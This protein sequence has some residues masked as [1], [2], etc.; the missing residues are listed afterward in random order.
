MIDIHNDP[1]L[2]RASVRFTS[3]QT[4]FAPRLIEK[5]YFCSLLLEYFLPLKDIV[6]KG[7]TCLAKVH[8]NFYRLSEYLDFTIPIDSTSNRKQ[9]HIAI[10]PVKESCKAL[11]KQLQVFTFAESMRGAN[12]SMQY[13]AKLSYES[14]VERNTDI[15][16]FE[17]SLR[18]PLIEKIEKFDTHT[19]LINPA[20]GK[21]LVPPL[22]CSCISKQEAYAEKFRAALTR[23][24]PAIRDYYDIDY[25]IRNLNLDP[26]KDDFILLVKGKVA[27]PGNTLSEKFAYNRALLEKQL[28]TE[29]K[30]VLRGGE[31]EKF[32]LN[33]TYSFVLDMYKRLL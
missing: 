11:V 30:P 14:L 22:Q 7:G 16:K 2:F 10:E 19:I 9:R 5:D 13:I 32:D 23:R 21:R 6:F 12:E 31:Y 15:V 20:N 1:E 24:E 29:L 4:G 26:S 33:R 18:E 28:E 8:A 27:V 3:E 25:A 17:I